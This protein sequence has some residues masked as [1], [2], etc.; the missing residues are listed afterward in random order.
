MNLKSF[1]AGVLVSF[2]G[3]SVLAWSQGEPTYELLQWKEGNWYVE[4]FNLS[5][6]DCEGFAEARSITE[7]GVY[8]CRLEN[9][10]ESP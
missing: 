1:L 10:N 6:T 3:V 8:E 9:S 2:L 4:D 5:R 7:H